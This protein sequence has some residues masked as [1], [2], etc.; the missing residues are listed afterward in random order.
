MIFDVDQSGVLS[1]GLWILFLQN[2][3]KVE[4]VINC[5]LQHTW[6]LFFFNTREE[7]YGINVLTGFKE[8]AS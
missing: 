6:I 7:R 2:F 8:C 3:E 4:S 5:T 1:V